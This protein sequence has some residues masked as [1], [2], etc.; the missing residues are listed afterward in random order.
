[1]ST[2][3]VRMYVQTGVLTD[4]RVQIYMFQHFALR[5]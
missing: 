2:Q 3:D 4:G 5:A 1:L